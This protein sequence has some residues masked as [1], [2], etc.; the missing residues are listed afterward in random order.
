MAPKNHQNVA[1]CSVPTSSTKQFSH[2]VK[3]RKRSFYFWDL[4]SNIIMMHFI[5]IQYYDYFSVPRT[6]YNVERN[7]N[8]V[9]KPVGRHFNVPRPKQHMA[10][11]VL[12]LHLGGSESRKTLE[13]KFIC[14]I[15]TLN[16]HGINK[17]F[18][19]NKFTL[20]FSSP[21]SHQ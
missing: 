18:L 10:V 17:S 7:D 9:S 2:Y 13:H 20:V 12:F 11:C 15:G 16:P 4:K 5:P 19:F 8:D 21:Y 6:P 3:T 14:Q 1:S